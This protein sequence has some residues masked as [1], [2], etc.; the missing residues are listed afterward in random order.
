MRRTWKATISNNPTCPGCLGR[1]ER[2]S[3]GW[4]RECDGSAGAARSFRLAMPSPHINHPN[5]VFHLGTLGFPVDVY[6]V[7]SSF[8]FSGTTMG[9][10]RTSIRCGGKS[11]SFVTRQLAPAEPNL[12][13][14][15]ATDDLNVYSTRPYPHLFFFFPSGI[16]TWLFAPELAQIPSEWSY[17]KSCTCTVLYM[18]LISLSSS[19]WLNVNSRQINDSTWLAGITLF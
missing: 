13:R 17:T 9:F 11:H 4:L 16:D 1:R 10:T 15:W 12:K 6:L 18:T 7:S 19:N 2:L 14:L 8:P 3:A 5:P